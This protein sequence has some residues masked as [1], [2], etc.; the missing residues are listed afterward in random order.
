MKRS[1][2]QFVV[3]V[4]LCGSQA[5]VDAHAGDER[6]SSAQL[7]ESSASVSSSQTYVW[8]FSLS[9]SIRAGRNAS[10]AIEAWSQ[11]VGR[12][13]STFRFYLSKDG[14]LDIT[15]DKFLG[16]L[17][18]SLTGPTYG[19]QNSLFYGSV[20]IPPTTTAGSYFFFLTIDGRE[21]TLSGSYFDERIRIQK[22]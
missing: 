12:T 20:K 15:R 1:V 11:A 6:N 7:R 3:S 16:K 18:V 9:S 22:R 4:V 5:A 2:F 10:I 19:N 14:R 21:R 17:Q 13:T 8:D